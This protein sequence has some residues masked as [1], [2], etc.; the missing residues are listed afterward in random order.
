MADNFYLYFEAVQGDEANDKNILENGISLDD[1]FTNTAYKIIKKGETVSSVALF[2]LL[3]TETPIILK[4]R[5]DSTFAFIA[6]IN[7]NIK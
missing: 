7:I 3:D 2:S 4:V 5:D 6:K 1:D